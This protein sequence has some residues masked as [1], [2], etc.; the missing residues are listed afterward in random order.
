MKRTL[1]SDLKQI[2]FSCQLGA[3]RTGD[4]SLKRSNH[5]G[6]TWPHHSTFS[7]LEPQ[8]HASWRPDESHSQRSPQSVFASFTKEGARFGSQALLAK[9]NRTQGWQ[10]EP[11]HHCLHLIARRTAPA[12]DYAGSCLENKITITVSRRVMGVRRQTPK[13]WYPLPDLTASCSPN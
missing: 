2:D 3:V 4:T 13:A 8:P 10:S 11:L 12:E 9:R 7:V 1:E 5:V 6:T